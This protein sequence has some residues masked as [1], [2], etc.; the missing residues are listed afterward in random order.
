[1]SRLPRFRGDIGIK[2]GRI[3]E[4]GHIAGSEA[5]ETIDAGGLIVA[6]GFVDPSSS[7]ASRRRP[8]RSTSCPTCRSRRS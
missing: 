4:I 1:G 6:P 5:D 2:D 3:A 8:R 7:T